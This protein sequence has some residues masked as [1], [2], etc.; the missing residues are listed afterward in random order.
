MSYPI[1]SIMAIGCFPCQDTNPLLLEG[2]FGGLSDCV[3]W[4]V[5]IIPNVGLNSGAA[6]SG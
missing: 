2:L 4:P 1:Y 3:D 5:M 6:R